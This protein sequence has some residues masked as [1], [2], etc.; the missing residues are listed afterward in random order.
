MRLGSTESDEHLKEF[1]AQKHFYEGNQFLLTPKTS[2][3][4]LFLCSLFCLRELK[5]Q[6]ESS[7][8]GTVAQIQRQ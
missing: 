3:T 5:L 6:E 1:V 2:E 7:R 8:A 4:N